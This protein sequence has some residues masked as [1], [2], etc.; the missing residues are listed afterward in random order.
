[1]ATASNSFAGM[2]TL[3][4][5]LLFAV[6]GA[7]P[8]HLPHGI[9]TTLPFPT[10]S[11][12]W[13]RRAFSNGTLSD[14]PAEYRVPSYFPV[15]NAT[16]NATQTQAAALSLSLM[17]NNP[18][19]VGSF[20]GSQGAQSGHLT[21]ELSSSSPFAG[22][23]TPNETH[24]RSTSAPISAATSTKAWPL[25]MLTLS[26][27]STNQ[28]KADRQ[29][30]ASCA[31]TVH[32]EKPKGRTLPTLSSVD[33]RAWT[34]MVKGH[35]VLVLPM[36]STSSTLAMST[37]DKRA[38]PSSTSTAQPSQTSLPALAKTTKMPDK[39]KIGIIAGS[40]IGAFTVG[41]VVLYVTVEGILD[42]IR[43]LKGYFHDI[44]LD[45][46][47]DRFIRG[48]KLSDSSSETTTDT[49]DV[50]SATDSSE[51]WISWE[52]EVEYQR[53]MRQ[54]ARE[55]AQMESYLMDQE[56]ELPGSV[57][58]EAMTPWKLL[59]GEEM[60]VTA[61]APFP[62]GFEPQPPRVPP[63]SREPSGVEDPPG[64]AEGPAEGPS[65]GPS[66]GGQVPPKTP[67][68]G[69]QDP[70][71]GPK[72][73]P[74]DQP[75]PSAPKTPHLP[76][77]NEGTAKGKGKSVQWKDP[78]ESIP[79]SFSLPPTPPE[80]PHIPEIPKIPELPGL[81]HV[82]S[83]PHLPELPHIPS[84][85]HLPG[86]P[87][88]PHLPHLPGLPHLP[89]IGI[90]GGHEGGDKGEG[91]G[92]G[93][94]KGKG[95]DKGKGKGKGKDKGKGKGKGKD[96]GSKP[97]D[98][99]HAPDGK[100]VEKAGGKGEGKG[101]E[102][103]TASEPTNGPEPTNTDSPSS[104][105]EGND[106][107]P[108]TLAPET[109]T[110]AHAPQGN[111]GA[112]LTLSSE[113]AT[114]ANGLTGQDGISQ[115][116]SLETA[117]LANA[118]PANDGISL[119]LS[120]ET[121]RDS[122]IVT[123]VKP[124]EG[125][126]DPSR[127]LRS[128]TATGSLRRSHSEMPA[129][130]PP[131][132]HVLSKTQ[133]M[134]SILVSA[135]MLSTGSMP[136]STT[137]L[138][139]PSRGA[140]MSVTSASSVTMTTGLS[141]ITQPSVTLNTVPISIDSTTY[142]GVPVG[143]SRASSGAR[144]TD[145]DFGVNYIL[146]QLSS[147]ATNDRFDI[148]PRRGL[149]SIGLELLDAIEIDSN[150]EF[151]RE[152]SVTYEVGLSNDNVSG[153]SG[154]RC[155]HNSSI[156]GI[157]VISANGLY[158]FKVIAFWITTIALTHVLL[159]SCA[160]CTNASFKQGNHRHQNLNFVV[161]LTYVIILTDAL[162]NVIVQEHTLAIVFISSRITSSNTGIHGRY[163][164]NYTNNT[165]TALTYTLTIS[166]ISASSPASSPTTSSASAH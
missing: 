98:E 115:T 157:P 68:L 138:I 108:Q 114:L 109:A 66:K 19:T 80:I 103:A 38:L 83:L 156:G 85:P 76:P 161:T 89:H 125:T 57:Y 158:N 4:T 116:F 51:S 99:G 63:S 73:P 15:A 72:N 163:N 28:A 78:L 26:T 58:P 10:A 96:T 106:D 165:T 107:T 65:E 16:R 9:V 48:G 27:S 127:S 29:G 160:S 128:Q 154:I 101:N 97:G 75:G 87:H 164:L 3:I 105:T 12:F 130:T 8:T 41:N 32:T 36:P 35:T 91:D 117:T 7:V 95:K 40:A 152:G 153:V 56:Y 42:Q 142:S 88:L 61:F 120:P 62:P 67:K 119:T 134:Y 141:S 159:I 102:K 46:A 143:T 162:T 74:A 149:V 139:S 23:G 49:E 112:S 14:G 47:I 151:R 21:A 145:L 111:D 22:S 17:S 135:T 150:I 2:T 64:P 11:P 45:A 5:M 104:K 131:T 144:V 69:P 147:G 100:D 6:V 34:T 132:P 113:T 118:P 81:P 129:T 39:E 146:I 82:P 59:F 166:P 122:D 52:D 20:S 71:K 110:L 90:P 31:S 25:S 55:L 86:L 93:K 50:H 44:D 84:L 148:N 140:V 24:K 94:G 137:T 1:M 60:P 136:P 133:S 155:V 126:D 33:P 53:L 77:K 121:V 70:N 13:L 123:H 18:V 124:S 43:R 37:K 79:D 92:K 54:E 30:P